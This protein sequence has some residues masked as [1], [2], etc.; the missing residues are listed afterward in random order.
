[1]ASN[2]LCRLPMIDLQTV[3]KA[4]GIAPVRPLPLPRP[5]PAASG[6]AEL[7]KALAQAKTGE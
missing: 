7:I 3:E 2:M 1:M 6:Y 5:H 4:A